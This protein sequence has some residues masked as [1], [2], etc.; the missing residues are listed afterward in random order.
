MV[1]PGTAGIRRTNQSERGSMT[2]S[3]RAAAVSTVAPWAPASTSESSRVRT[4]GRS[5]CSWATR[6]ISRSTSSM[7][8]TSLPR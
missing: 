8:T 3:T 2:G 5:F 4:W 6:W 1:S 7:S